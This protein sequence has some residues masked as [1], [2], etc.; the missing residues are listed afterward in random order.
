MIKSW[1]LCGIPKRTEGAARHWV[2]LSAYGA[3][4]RRILFAALQEVFHFCVTLESGSQPPPAE[5]LD[6]VLLFSFLLPFAFANLRAPLRETLSATDASESGGA[7]C[8]A[9]TFR[10]SMED[11][12]GNEVEAFRQTLAEE[13][14]F[15]LP[16][17]ASCGHC[18]QTF[19]G[20]SPALACPGKCGVLLCSLDCLD[21]HLN[22]SQ[23]CGANDLEGCF[24]EFVLYHRSMLSLDVAICGGQV[25]R[26][27]HEWGSKSLSKW[28]H[29]RLIHCEF[30]NL[31]GLPWNSSWY[32][33]AAKR[34]EFQLL[35]LGGCVLLVPDACK[36]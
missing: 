33:F 32:E 14:G 28:L 9:K 25:R 18:E 22:T 13:S 3:Q 10:A 36:F 1:L 6:E 34:L 20:E 30:W 11:G 19:S 15:D 4:F 26:L 8:E 29:Q 16:R 5:V 17:V 23:L 35:Q 7:A 21:A 24:V 12:K 27:P 2:G 31:F